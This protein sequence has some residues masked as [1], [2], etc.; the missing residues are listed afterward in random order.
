MVLQSSKSDVVG[1]LPDFVC[2]CQYITTTE[3]YHMIKLLLELANG[4]QRWI[5]IMRERTEDEDEPPKE[6]PLDDPFW[7]RGIGVMLGVMIDHERIICE[8]KDCEKSGL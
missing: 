1:N 5:Q 8:R 7:M 6:I 2:V 3:D 4:E